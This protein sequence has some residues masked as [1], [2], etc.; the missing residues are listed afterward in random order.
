MG[1]SSASWLVHQFLDCTLQVCK[2]CSCPASR[3]KKEPRDSD[4]DINDL[5]DRG[6]LHKGS[7][8]DTPPCAADGRQDMAA[9]F[10]T[11][12]RGGFHLQGELMSGGFISYQGLIKPYL[13][14][15]G[16]I[17]PYL[18]FPLSYRK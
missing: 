14:Y 16:L 18:T 10:N 9:V 13:T 1:V 17:K 3:L 2:P 7:G 8:S 11:Q 6:I 5:L 4:R 12:G 15:Q